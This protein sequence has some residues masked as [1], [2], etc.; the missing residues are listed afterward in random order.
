MR[1]VSER[2]EENGVNVVD[3]ITVLG[4]P[5]YKYEEEI[6][7]TGKEVKTLLKVRIKSYDER[8]DGRGYSETE[9]EITDW[10]RQAQSFVDDMY[11]RYEDAMK[12]LLKDS[13]ARKK[14][15]NP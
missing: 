3:L 6:T 12:K 7:K 4:K 11:P 15:S 9:V 5:D 8:E 13:Q 2:L 14:I 10:F 1:C